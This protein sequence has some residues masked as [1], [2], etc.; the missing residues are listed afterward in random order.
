MAYRSQER[1]VFW[2]TIEA[3]SCLG[4]AAEWI[5]RRTQVNSGRG[6]VEGFTGFISECKLG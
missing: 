2:L 6:S 4:L 3:E 5:T 1:I